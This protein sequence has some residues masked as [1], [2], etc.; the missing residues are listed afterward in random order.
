MFV[1][2]EDWD[3]LSEMSSDEVEANGKKEDEG[4]ESEE[5]DDDDSGEEEEEEEDMG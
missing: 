2:Q 3:D 4:V 5:E 1:L